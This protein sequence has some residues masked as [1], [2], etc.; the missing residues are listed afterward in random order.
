MPTDT[1]AIYKL[2]VQIINNLPNFPKIV[3]YFCPKNKNRI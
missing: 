1:A 2:V 3:F